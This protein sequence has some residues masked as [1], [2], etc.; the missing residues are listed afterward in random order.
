MAKDQR[1][2]TP[3]GFNIKENLL[4]HVTAKLIKLQV[5]LWSSGSS[6]SP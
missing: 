4:A 1:K 2:E 5:R 3:G 6:L